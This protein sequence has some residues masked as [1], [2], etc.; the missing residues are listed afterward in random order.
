MEALSR[1]CW[2]RLHSSLVFVPIPPS[3][4][5]CPWIVDGTWLTHFCSSLFM[6]L[7]LSYQ[8]ASL[9]SASIKYRPFP[10][11]LIHRTLLSLMSPI[12]IASAPENS[13]IPTKATVTVTDPDLSADGIS[14]TIYQ[15]VPVEQLE[16]AF[17]AYVGKL[18]RHCHRS[19]DAVSHSH[20]ELAI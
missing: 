18:R 3:L 15:A 6:R 5:L 13:V 11:L 10:Y 14:T 4:L 19:H 7:F 16:A 20:L 8:T 9:L 2:A 17:S 1:F 12:S